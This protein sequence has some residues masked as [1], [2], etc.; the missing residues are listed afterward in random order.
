MCVCVW[1][2]IFHN[3]T[4]LPGF[5]LVFLFLFLFVG[6]YW[7]SA[8]LA[9]LFNQQ[10]RQQQPGSRNNSQNAVAIIAAAMNFSLSFIYFQ[11]E[12]YFARFMLPIFFPLQSIALFIF[13]VVLF[14]T[15]PNFSRFYWLYYARK[16]L[17]YAY[18]SIN[19]TVKIWN[20]LIIGTVSWQL[21]IFSSF[22][23]FV[24]K[25]WMK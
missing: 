9:K 17:N 16:C 1:V 20:S 25:N 10:W 18:K 7:F 13:T 21:L 23:I 14:C 12:F 4:L 11:F 15:I 22:R 2:V 24:A 3:C 8:K 6:C 19:V 5:F